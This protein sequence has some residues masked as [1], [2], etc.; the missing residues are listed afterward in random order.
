MHDRT[1][2]FKKDFKK[3]NL[4]LNG[5]RLPTFKIENKYKKEVGVK[6]DV[7]NVEFLKALMRNGFNKIKSKMPMI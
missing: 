4:P 5:V 2:D 3:I 1:I 6:T 7:D